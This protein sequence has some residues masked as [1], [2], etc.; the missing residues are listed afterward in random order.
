MSAKH[1]SGPW[2]TKHDHDLEG[3]ITII[4]N[5]D[6][7]YH[8]GVPHCTYDVI[9]VCQDYFGESVPNAVANAR[10]IAQAPD[11]LAFAEQIA[12]LL[13][14]GEANGDGVVYEQD[15]DDAIGTLN[16]LITKA[17]DLTGIAKATGAAN[18]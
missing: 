2:Q 3:Q 17:R 11:L 8:D 7:E 10:L 5:V 12:R 1:T 9:A 4:G 18:V 6:G 16:S 15:P 13:Q 14:N